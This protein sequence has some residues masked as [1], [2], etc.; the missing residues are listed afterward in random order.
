MLKLNNCPC[1]NNFSRKYNVCACAQNVPSCSRDWSSH[2]MPYFYT[3][4][5]YHYLDGILPLT[6]HVNKKPILAV[7]QLQQFDLLENKTLPLWTR[8]IPRYIKF[9]TTV[10]FGGIFGGVWLVV[11][12]YFQLNN[13]FCCDWIYVWKS[14]KMFDAYRAR[15]E[16]HTVVKRSF[17]FKEEY[18]GTRADDC[19]SC[20]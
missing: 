11:S 10:D 19:R 9:P 7:N 16:C 13:L 6:G 8:A 18:W 1:D 17:N 20:L 15:C 5:L 2:I 3:C 4:S 14:L 12:C